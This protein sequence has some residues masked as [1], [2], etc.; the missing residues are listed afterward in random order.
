MTMRDPGTECRSATLGV[1]VGVMVGVAVGSG[2]GVTV[3]MRVGV[4]VGVGVGAIVGV[5]DDTGVGVK[6]GN[7]TWT[8]LGLV[9]GG[10][11]VT[12]NV[13]LCFWTSASIVAGM[14]GVGVGVVHARID[15][16]KNDNARYCMD[17]GTPSCG[18]NVG[19]RAKL[20]ITLGCQDKRGRVGAPSFRSPNGLQ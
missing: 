12:C 16:N 10:N 6:V 5:G 19:Y 4:G 13:A 14:S 8:V 15:K 17:W 18:E 3:G 9:V 1:G 2:V 20:A 11:P 7:G